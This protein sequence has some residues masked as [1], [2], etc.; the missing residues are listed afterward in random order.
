MYFLFSHILVLSIENAP[1]CRYYA[2]SRFNYLGD[3]HPPTIKGFEIFGTTLYCQHFMESRQC[4][5]AIF[6]FCHW[7]VFIYIEIVVCLVLFHIIRFIVIYVIIILLSYITL[8]IIRGFLIYF[9]YWTNILWILYLDYF[10]NV[11]KTTYM[12][13]HTYMYLTISM[14]VHRQQ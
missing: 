6:E 8:Y 13:I 11:T 5:S 4:I 7:Y 14:K 2:I 10:T 1:L 9:D 12:Y 3:F